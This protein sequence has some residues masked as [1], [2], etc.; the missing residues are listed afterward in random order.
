MEYLKEKVSYLRGLADGMKIDEAT[1]QGK[2]IKAIIETLDD[3]AEA[4]TD[5]GEEQ[6][7]IGE[8]VEDLDED[9]A[10]VEKDFY[11]DYDEEDDE[12]EEDD[13]EDYED[14][15]YEVECPNCHEK[16]VLEEDMLF[17][18][19]GVFCPNCNAEI[20]LDINDEDCDCGHHHGKKE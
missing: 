19:N 12:D 15:Y 6:D 3:F 18:E 14:E 8:Y 9:L 1:D 10:E 17:D 11:E 20:E 13:Y 5:L 4:I 7:Y 2:L 16:V